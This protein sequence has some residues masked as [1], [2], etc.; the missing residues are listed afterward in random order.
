MNIPHHHLIEVEIASLRP[1]QI[2]V[3]HAEVAKKRAEWAKLD[4][5]ERKQRLKQQWFPSVLGP[6]GK[7][8]IVDHHHLG[9]ALLEEGIENAWVTVLQDY[10]WLDNDRFWRVMDFHQ[11]AHPYDENGNRLTF[12]DIPKT[13]TDLRNDPYRSLAGFVRGAGGYAK[14]TTPFTEFL[15]ADYFRSLIKANQIDQDLQNTIDA[16]CKLAR[17]QDARYL[18]G[19]IGHPY[20]DHDKD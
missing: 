11:L 16:A 6:K 3:G 1:T 10:S 2:T 18:P 4:K 15:W 17:S 13:V 8:F 12:D 9:L 7:Y 5:K 20:H 19:W 14:D